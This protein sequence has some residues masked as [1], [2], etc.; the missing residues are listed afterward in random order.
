M[1]KHQQQ[2]YQHQNKSSIQNNNYGTQMKKLFS[3]I[4]SVHSNNTLL[5]D[6]YNEHIISQNI[7]TS[8][9]TNSSLKEKYIEHDISQ[10]TYSTKCVR[11]TDTLVKEKYIEYIKPL[12][13]IQY[14]EIS[15][16]LMIHNQCNNYRNL[17][18][19]LLSDHKELYNEYKKIVLKF[20]SELGNEL[21]TLLLVYNF[22]VPISFLRIL[23]KYDSSLINFLSD[24]M[25]SNLNSPLYNNSF[26]YMF[27]LEYDKIDK[28]ETV[29]IQ[30]IFNINSN[31]IFQ[32]MMNI[33][34][35]FIFKFYLLSIEYMGSKETTLECI[36]KDIIPLYND[37][38][39][40]LKF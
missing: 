27:E 8:H 30:N 12:S 37:L 13:K 21:C 17:Y 29:N 35:K 23:Y 20:K 5:K 6:K 4:N 38:N 16:N 19:P 36:Q 39:K 11:I 18:Q 22:F 7:N 33:M 25:L 10:N 14:L 9:T 3:N 31:Y 15:S 26:I 34:N 32:E 1:V 28:I 24:K 40:I 2:L